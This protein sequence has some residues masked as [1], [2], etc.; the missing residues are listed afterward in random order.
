V[1]GVQTCALP[2]YN[3]WDPTA[4][5]ISARELGI[6]ELAELAAQGGDNGEDATAYLKQLEAVGIVA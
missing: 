4:F 6:D 5:S 2:I 1:T 3:E